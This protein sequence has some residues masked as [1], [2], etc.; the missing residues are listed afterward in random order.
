MD[1]LDEYV[2]GYNRCVHDWR[3][4]TGTDTVEWC[5]MCGCL[6][7]TIAKKRYI[8]YPDEQDGSDD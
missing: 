8:K 5:A 7:E 6:A 1:K 3:R 4:I 2:K